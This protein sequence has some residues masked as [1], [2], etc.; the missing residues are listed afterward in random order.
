MI[1][2]N[3]KVDNFYGLED[4]E[5]NF[6]YPKKIVNTT[7]PYEYL[8]ERPNFRF[9]RVNILMGANASGK[10]VIGKAMMDILNFIDNPIYESL[11]NSITNIKKKASFEID[12]VL[13]SKTL[14]RVIFEY[15]E[16]H[17]SKIEI[18]KKDISK[19]D[20]YE[21]TVKGLKKIKGN[22]TLF[23]PNSESDFTINLYDTLSVFNNKLRWYFTFP[24]DDLDY[25]K[26]MDLKVLNIILKSFDPSIEEVKLSL[27]SNNVHI[28]VFKNGYKLFV[29][30]GRVIKGNILSSGTQEGISIA[31]AITELKGKNAKP[32]YIDEKFSHAQSNIEVNIL[33]LMIDLLKK[34]S[35]LFFTT[36]NTDILEMNLP[37]HS[38]TFL[39]KNESIEVIYPS[40]TLKR[41]D[42]SLVNAVKNDLF[43]TIPDTDSL[44]KI[45]DDLEEV[46][47]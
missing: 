43:N 34:E 6:S 29:Q 5:I 33:N 9:K 23:N 24:N 30:D 11:K 27:E 8:E 25:F 10:T 12:F 35:Q 31:H 16:G 38:Y 36:H 45:L 42:G 44:Y 28:I 26:N 19:K 1:I 20:N 21:S 46:I 40:N 41:N 14:Y 15:N 17:Q 37:V 18:F 7:I 3:M 32:F 2:M 22:I 13:E 39:K 47:E 4:F